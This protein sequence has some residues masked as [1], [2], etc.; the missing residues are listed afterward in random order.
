MQNKIFL[1]I[2]IILDI[3][4]SSRPNHQNAIKIW[5]ISVVKKY[6]ICISEDM[7]STIFYINR[8]KKVT[9]EFFKTIQ[10]RWTIA[11]FGK[12]VIADAIELSLEKDLDLEDALQCIC[13]KENGCNILITNDK[14]FYDCGILIMSAEKFL[15]ER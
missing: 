13:A 4:D 3:L 9:L 15:S 2:N 5:E 12:K 8:D 14:K 11:M 10:K 7:L 6:Q 1:D